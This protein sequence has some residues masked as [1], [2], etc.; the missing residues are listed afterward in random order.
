MLRKAIFSQDGKHRLLLIRKWKS[1]GK[2]GCWIMLNPSK[3]DNVRDD[4][5]V[6]WLIKFSKAHGY[7]KFYVLNLFTYIT[8]EPKVLEVLKEA[9]ANK[10]L[11]YKLISKY[12]LKADVVICGWGTWGFIDR[13]GNTVKNLLKSMKIKAYCLGLSEGGHPFHPMFVARKG[14]SFINQIKLQRYV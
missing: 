10:A 3:A 13:Q 2:V 1:K 12:A 7:R 9:K 4:N 14:D 5:T 11:N 8:S 6:R